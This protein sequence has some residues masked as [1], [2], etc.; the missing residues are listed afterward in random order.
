M[1]EHVD[2]TTPT[3]TT[4]STTLPTTGG[5]LEMLLVCYK[6]LTMARP[7]AGQSLIFLLAGCFPR[8]V[9]LAR[10]PPAPVECPST[11]VRSGGSWPPGLSS[12]FLLSLNWCGAIGGPLTFQPFAREPLVEAP[13]ESVGRRAGWRARPSCDAG[14]YII[15][16]LS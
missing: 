8:L 3:P 1:N 6:E 11:L 15:K 13:P 12:I 5:E 16:S 9:S 7:V 10:A 2:A 14:G 4:T